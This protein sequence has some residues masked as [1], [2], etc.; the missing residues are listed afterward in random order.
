MA[1]SALNII[2]EAAR[3][4]A[5]SD[6][7]FYTKPVYF[8][9]LRVPAEVGV[10]GTSFLFPLALNPQEITLEEPFTVD[11]QPTQGGGLYVEENGIVQRILRIR[12]HTGFKPRKMEASLGLG[13][14]LSPDKS[15]FSREIPP[16]V[17]NDIGSTNVG[18]GLSGQRHFQW[19]QDKVFRTYAD[20]KRDPATSKD[21]FMLWHNQKDDEHWIV[22]PQQFTLTRSAS[23]PTLYEY[24]IELLVVDK[25]EAADLEL[26]ED[27]GL[28][29]QIKDG[30]RQVQ[31]AID[32]A[33]GAIADVT[34]AVAEIR[35]VIAAVDQI[36]DSVGQVI[37]AASDFVQ[38]V[39]DLIEMP[40]A[41][42]QSVVDVLD[43]TNEFL[44]ELTELGTA[45]QTLP[46]NLQQSFRQMGDAMEKI[47]SYPG[48]FAKPA[49]K[50]LKDQ[51]KRQ[52]LSTNTSADALAG[53]SAAAPTTIDGFR[54][55][56]TGLMPGD[57]QKAKADTTFGRQSPQFTS[58]KEQKLQQGDSLQSLAQRYLGDARLWK[59]IANANGLKPPFVTDLEVRD[60]TRGLPLPG[61][62]GRG[63]SILIPSFAKPP[64][65][66]PLLTTHGVAPDEPNDVHLLGRD[67]ALVEDP[68]TGLLDIPIDTEGGAID[69]KY[70]AGIPN[71]QQGIKTRLDTE[72]GSDILYRLLGVQR[73]VGLGN[74]IIDL[75]SARFRVGEAVTTDPRIASLI[76]I[77]F[78]NVDDRMVIDMT[79]E[80]RGFSEPIQISV[81][82]R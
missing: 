41:L 25:G 35:S 74:R 10:V 72:K 16:V 14:L 78:E 5:L 28:I 50:V 56:G 65:A 30:L 64:A 7:K 24:N 39:T 66:Q 54:N 51:Q 3:Q 70:V 52:Q 22:V 1:V 27:K 21:T 63:D 75:E 4:T 36:I 71:L 69:A 45:I 47:T 46:A 42:A 81:P 67:F 34:A 68:E 49:D 11:A 38:G 62:L 31:G 76:Q 59:H 20:L 40:L 79:V 57:A 26:S 13:F 53:A 12:G 82:T 18:K 2:A 23:R 8:F 55:L 43:E 48:M 61:T 32:L 37:D 19:L 6:F 29:D 80:V 33:S 9:E 44:T 17:I 77:D 73:V 58:V 60:L 15:S